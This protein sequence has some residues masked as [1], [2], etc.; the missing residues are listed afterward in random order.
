[1]TKPL[2]TPDKAGDYYRAYRP[3]ENRRAFERTWNNRKL[4]QSHVKWSPL[5]EFLLCKAPA[6]AV[7]L[8]W[9]SVAIGVHRSRLKSCCGGR[10]MDIQ[11][12][13]HCHAAARRNSF[14]YLH[15]RWMHSS[16]VRLLP[17]YQQQQTIPNTP[18]RRCLTVSACLPGPLLGCVF[19]TGSPDIST[20]EP[21]VTMLKRQVC[22]LVPATTK[23]LNAFW[24]WSPSPK[25]VTSF[26]TS[27]S[28][29]CLFLS[30]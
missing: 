17:L 21:P 28:R 12:V 16:H 18:C 4:L 24:E 1:M 9:G 19:L 30:V 5:A 8:L 2:I 6:L 7:S 25:V 13:Q 23:L 22:G 3:S 29:R 26:S 10:L 11:P 27:S 14:S 20:R 15:W